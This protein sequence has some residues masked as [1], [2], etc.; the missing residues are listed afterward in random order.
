[1]QYTRPTRTTLGL[2]L[3]LLAG[4]AL[5]A[6]PAYAQEQEE[7]EGKRVGVPRG[8]YDKP[9]IARLGRGTAVGGY[10]DMEFETNFNADGDVTGVTFDQHRLI[11]F[12]FSEVTDR[13]H[14]AAELEFEHGGNPSK[15]GE[16]K[17]EFA[18]IDFT[19]REWLNFRAG[20]LL[21]PLGYFNLVHDS[22]WNDLTERPLVNRALIPTTLSEAGMGFNGSFYPNPMNVVHYELYLVNGFN[23]AVL[24]DANRDGQI[25]GVRIRGGR[26]SA[27]QDNNKGKSVVGRLSWSP[28]LGMQLGGSFHTGAYDNTGD[29]NLTI[30][31]ADAEL[32][33]GPV[34][35]LAEYAHARIGLDRHG[36]DTQVQHGFYVQ[37]NY[38]LLT[39]R[40]LQGSVVTLVGRYDFVD[41]ALSGDL[42]DAKQDRLTLGVNFR[43][44]EDTVFK[45]DWGFN[46]LTPAGGSRE[47][48]GSTLFF[49]VASYF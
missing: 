45:L 24:L 15:D 36:F 30:V 47:S 37:G 9:Y 31:A 39:D 49:S 41:Y 3:L 4:L 16:I 6:A 13:I 18:A 19:M 11:P 8:I 23:E 14:F 28:Q 43:P 21:S 44:V 25:E 7:E 29:D 27:K 1:M 17:V 32:T 20:I 26:G 40:V 48:K 42:A 33:R 35:L 2:F 12:I 46:G 38:H 5:Q 34:Q 22:P 10:M